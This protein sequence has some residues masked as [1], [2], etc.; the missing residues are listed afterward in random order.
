M[1]PK[2]VPKVQL[3]IFQHWFRYDGL[4]STKRQANIWTNDDLGY[5]RIH[6]S[7]GL[8]DLSLDTELQ[9]DDPMRNHSRS[10][11]S[12]SHDKHTLG[13]QRTT[14]INNPVISVLVSV[15]STRVRRCKVAYFICIDFLWQWLNLDH[16]FRIRLD[17]RYISY[18]MN[19]SMEWQQ[20]TWHRVPVFTRISHFTRHECWN[21]IAC[22]KK[23]ISMANQNSSGPFY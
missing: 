10:V 4:A 20:K 3:T 16:H 13:C 23:E 12:I 19:Y 18:V 11:N 2:F 6:A 22:G 15:S 14:Q 9:K 17:I 1:S 8:D 21:H 5:R 7:L